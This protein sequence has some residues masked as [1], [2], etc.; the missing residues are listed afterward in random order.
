MAEPLVPG[1]AIDE[2]G[3]AA[4]QQA[5]LR[6]PRAVGRERRRDPVRR[7]VHGGAGAAADLA[8]DRR[9]RGRTRRR[10]STAG[11]SCP[12]SI[13]GL[14]LGPFSGI[15]FLWFV[16]VIRDQIGEREDRFFA[17]VFFGSGAAVRRAPVRGAGRRELHRRW[18]SGSSTC[19]RRPRTRSGVTRSLAYTLL[20]GFA[21]RA[22]AVFLFSTA[23]L[24]LRTRTFPTWFALTGYA[25]G[26]LLLLVVNIWDWVVLLLPAWVFVISLSI[27]RREWAARRAA[28]AG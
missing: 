3:E 12:W 15:A 4:L 21:T 13:G 5:A 9:R 10:R 7:A 18:A 24:G 25:A 1:P 8:A 23:T 14:Y 20:F 26:V 2:A 16:A 28:A 6:R 11:G 22:A 19:G 17:T 27:L